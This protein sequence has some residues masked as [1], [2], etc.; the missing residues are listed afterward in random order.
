MS[1]HQF[2][3]AEPRCKGIT[4]VGNPCQRQTNSSDGYC[5]NAHRPKTHGHLRVGTLDTLLRTFDEEKT[6]LN[7]IIEKFPKLK[8]DIYATI[9]FFVDDGQVVALGNPIKSNVLYYAALLDKPKLVRYLL[10]FFKGFDAKEQEKA[11]RHISD[12]R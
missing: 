4:A 11:L 7:R 1:F 2:Q 8:E 6:E 5:C 3:R 10:T 9:T 12:D